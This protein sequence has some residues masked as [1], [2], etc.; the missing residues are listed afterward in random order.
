M[1]PT[2]WH[3]KWESNQIGFHKTEANPMLV[4]H[5]Q[6]LPLEKHTRLFLPLCGKTL[7]IAWLLSKGYK[8]AGAE[9]SEL[10]IEQLFEQLGVTPTRSRQGKHI[11]YSHNDIDIF[12]GDLFDLTADMVGNIDAI[13]DRAALVA[14][15]EEMRFSYTPHLINLT[16]NATQLLISF[17]YDQSLVDGPPFSVS[18]TEVTHHYEQ[19]YHIEL[20]ERVDVPGGLKGKYDLTESVWLLTDPAAA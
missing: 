1:D 13:Y 5:L 18:P 7:D 6:R 2:F 11:H 20:I 16:N 17:E 15:P 10:A 9:L 14:L 12:A 8:V 4:R 3:Q 19:S